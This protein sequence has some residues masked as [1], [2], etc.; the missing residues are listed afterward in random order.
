MRN[1]FVFYFVFTALFQAC[2]W[3][4]GFEELGPEMSLKL[5]TDLDGGPT[6][7]SVVWLRMSAWISNS[8]DS[9]L[10]PTS[11]F[12]LEVHK[13]ASTNPNDLIAVLP[14]LS[15][16]DSGAIQWTKQAFQS[17]PEFKNLVLNGLKSD[18]LVRLRFR[19]LEVRNREGLEALNR[20]KEQQAA[21]YAVDEF[22]AYIQLYR[23]DL[24]S[25]PFSPFVIKETFQEKAK[26]LQYGDSIR[27]RYLL[28]T[29]DGR[30][31]EGDWSDSGQLHLK[32]GPSSLF[33]MAFFEG[34]MQF[35]EGEQGLLLIPYTHWSSN[36]PSAWAKYGLH[37][38]DN[39]VY[40][41][42]VERVF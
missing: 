35:K 17:I 19:V 10:E 11:G 29:L 39:L 21:A 5:D 40:K 7:D 1:H 31:V 14:H 24:V 27:I 22:K 20:E 38:F 34:L 41:I 42:D 12:N 2:G 15:A 9:I 28:L 8:E 32:I 25:I 18:S 37:A 4:S 23:P 6:G 3:G 26:Q 36:P 33:P 16:G 30:P 13:V